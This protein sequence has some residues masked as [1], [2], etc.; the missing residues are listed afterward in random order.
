MLPLD[1]HTPPRPQFPPHAG[2]F[3]FK[4]FLPAM[5]EYRRDGP[6]LHAWHD[7]VASIKVHVLRRLVDLNADKSNILLVADENKKM[8]VYSGTSVVSNTSL[9]QPVSMCVFCTSDSKSS[10]PAIGIAGALCF[11]SG[12]CGPTLS[13]PCLS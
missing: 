1:H 12:I 13:S 8:R 7:P 6:W 5:D 2:D 11:L 10:T 4:A 9:N 3:L